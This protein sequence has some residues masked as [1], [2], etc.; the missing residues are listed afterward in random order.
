MIK[1]LP[2]P[3]HRKGT[4][5]KEIYKEKGCH[6]ENLSHILICGSIPDQS[7]IC[8]GCKSCISR[9]GKD[10]QVSGNTSY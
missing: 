3:A 2:E 8:N 4:S 6:T 10:N 1:G 5:V 9:K 7:G